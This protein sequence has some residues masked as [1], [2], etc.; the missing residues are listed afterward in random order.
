MGRFAIVADTSSLIGEEVE[1][2][3]QSHRLELAKYSGQSRP[4][5]K[6]FANHERCISPHKRVFLGHWLKDVHKFKSK[7]PWSE[8]TT[9]VDRHTTTSA[10]EPLWELSV[11][12]DELNLT[13][14][15]G[16]L[17]SRGRAVSFAVM[18]YV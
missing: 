17:Q 14:Q 18:L 12:N 15:Q 11:D 10:H 7:G 8:T 16:E 5:R 6:G 2:Y 13:N 3:H 9:P 1:P 4:H